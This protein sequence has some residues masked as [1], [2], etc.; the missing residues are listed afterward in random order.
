MEELQGREK[1][2]L[3]MQLL[4][5][6]ISHCSFGEMFEE[7][8]GG[9]IV[10]KTYWMGK[11]ILKEDVLMLTDVTELIESFGLVDSVHRVHY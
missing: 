1:T 7:R 3:T 4:I 9:G 2:S 11:A 8:F 6:V 10:K 5:P